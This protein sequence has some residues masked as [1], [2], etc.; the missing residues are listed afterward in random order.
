MLEQV[1]RVVQSSEQ[2]VWVKPSEPQGCGVCAG[3]GC[4][5][6]RIAELF[7]RVPRQYQVESPLPL[8]IGDHVIV[9]MPEGSV[10]RSALMLYGLPLILMLMGALLAQLW[11]AGDS[12]AVIGAVV[13]L[14]TS[15]VL[16][17]RTSRRHPASMR[18]IV[19]G[20]SEASYGSILEEEK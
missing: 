5:S 2:G 1:A 10:L 19:I 6:R 3:Q 8:S 9:G 14:L 4:A 11:F 7:Q 20:R 12:G 17:I 13:G 15:G 18:P 16:I